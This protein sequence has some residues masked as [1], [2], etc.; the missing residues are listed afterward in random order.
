MKPLIRRILLGV[1]SAA[2]ALGALSACGH[3]REHRGWGSSA[4]EQDRQRDRIVERVAR[5]LELSDAQKDKLRAL[6]GTLQAQRAALQAHGDP[7][8]QLRSLVAGDKFDRARALDL[9]R[10]TAA[11]IEA[12]SPAVVSAFGDFYDSLDARQ[13]AMVR[14]RM[15]GRRGWWHRG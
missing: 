2:I 6:A 3:A 7:R 1:A 8:T 5:R 10:T 11:A 4:Q 15:E 12:R 13:Q 9:A 14:Q